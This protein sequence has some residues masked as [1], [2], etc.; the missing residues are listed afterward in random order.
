MKEKPS[1]KSLN[2]I[3]PFNQAQID[4]CKGYANGSIGVI[5]SGVIWLTSAFTA[6]QYSPKKA[7]WTLFIGGMFIY[8]I[9]IIISK[10]IGLN[11][12]HTKGNQLGNLA[13]EGTIWMI[14]CLPLAF[15]LSL[16]HTEWFFQAMLLIIGG[17]YLTFSTIY[18]NK[19]YWLLGAILG[20]SAYLLYNFQVQ[21]FGSLLTGSFI[22]ISF[23]LF[24]FLSFR[25]GNIKTMK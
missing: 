13:M 22:E 15:G 5:V 16:Q 25:S 20:T 24:M 23:G 12:T 14:M 17:R 11:G 8:P 19:I 7:I 4:M 18:G 2:Q 9:S 6:N 3:E 1:S 10:F 21:S